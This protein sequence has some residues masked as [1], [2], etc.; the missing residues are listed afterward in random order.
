MLPGVGNSLCRHQQNSSTKSKRSF[1]KTKSRHRPLGA[2]SW[3]TR[4]S[5]LHFARA[6]FPVSMSVHA[7]AR[8]SAIELHGP[9][10]QRRIRSEINDGT[11]RT[12]LQEKLRKFL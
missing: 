7:L 6:G 1:G 9:N 4:H 11:P 12:K 2:W 5:S 10:M 8:S 3:T